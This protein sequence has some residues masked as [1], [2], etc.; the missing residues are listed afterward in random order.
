[1]P[2]S[3][4]FKNS[5]SRTMSPEAVYPVSLPQHTSIV[6]SPPHP[7]APGAQMLPQQVEAE[8][9]LLGL[10]WE[11]QG[12][13]FLSSG[14]PLF[15]LRVGPVAWDLLNMALE[16]SQAAQAACSDFKGWDRFFQLFTSQPLP[17]CRRE[18][19]PG[20]FLGF[21]VREMLLWDKKWVVIGFLELVFSEDD[22]KA[23][24]A[25]KIS[26]TRALENWDG[27][28]IAV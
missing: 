22:I 23:H 12:V 9:A 13:V 28:E 4:E 3:I 16:D 21:E 20:D 10:D 26:V 7:P 11:I 27:S 25:I 14:E 17:Y 19:V 2:G 18:L 24:K 5:P 8:D 6:S 15:R 1:M